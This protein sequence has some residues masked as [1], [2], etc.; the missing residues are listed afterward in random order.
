MTR[1]RLISQRNEL[2]KY[3][4]ASAHKL[5][6]ELNRM[7]DLDVIEQVDQPTDWRSP[8]VVVPKNNGAVRTYGHFNQLNR[9]EK[10]EH[11]PKPT[12]EET[13][14][15]LAGRQSSS[16]SWMLTLDIGNENSGLNLSTL[17]PS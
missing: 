17:Q 9:T 2:T 10:R 16:Q 8:V 1:Q 13:L 14:V 3:F 4:N 12:T 7:E 15:K 5:K 11:H 6:T